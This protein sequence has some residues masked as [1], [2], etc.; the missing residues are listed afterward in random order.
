MKTQEEIVESLAGL[1][2]YAL[3][4]IRTRCT[5]LLQDRGWFVAPDEFDRGAVFISED[6]EEDN[7]AQLEFIEY[8][9]NHEFEENEDEEPEL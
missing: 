5:V 7:E 2:C 1:D 4:V 9:D 6:E 3:E 8:L